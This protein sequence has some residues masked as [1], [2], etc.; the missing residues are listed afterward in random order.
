M[1]GDCFDKNRIATLATH[2]SDKATSECMKRPFQGRYLAWAL[3]DVTHIGQLGN[4]HHCSE[5]S[6]ELLISTRSTR[7]VDDCPNVFVLNFFEVG[8]KFCPQIV[9]IYHA[10]K[11]R[12]SIKIFVWQNGNFRA[13]FTIDV[14]SFVPIK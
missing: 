14:F 5:H 8:A 2:F 12:I 7:V 4:F 13:G 3:R 1:P 6:Q 10:H 9:S 11:T